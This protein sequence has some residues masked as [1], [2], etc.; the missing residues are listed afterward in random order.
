[1][2]PYLAVLGNN[3]YATLP[4]LFLEKMDLSPVTVVIAEQASSVIGTLNR[5]SCKILNQ[6]V[7]CM[8]L[9]ELSGYRQQT[10]V[11]YQLSDREEALLDKFEMD[12]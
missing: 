10:T 6:L 8:K 7:G 4:V 2:Q 9:R 11:H 1:M 3:N 12:A 5:S